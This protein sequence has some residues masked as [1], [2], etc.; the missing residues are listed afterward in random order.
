MTAMLR[1]CREVQEE[2]LVTAKGHREES[3]AYFTS[4]HARSQEVLQLQV[5]R[6]P[7]LMHLAAG[8]GISTRLCFSAAPAPQCGKA[9]V[10]KGWS[11]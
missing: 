2:L 11:A 7:W 4:L 10:G 6:T 5:R 3:L 1:V 8:L 9:A